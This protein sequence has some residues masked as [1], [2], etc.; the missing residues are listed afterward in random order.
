MKFHGMRVLE[1]RDYKAFLLRKYA[2]AFNNELNCYAADQITF[3]NQEEALLWADEQERI[4]EKAAIRK[5]A[6]VKEDRRNR[7]ILIA[8][9][10]VVGFLIIRTAGRMITEKQYQNE[11]NAHNLQHLQNEIDRYNYEK[12][13]YP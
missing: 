9:A 6:K 5:K 12:N 7:Y 11:I 2:I 3:D 13:R 8:V 1:D 10:V 4:A